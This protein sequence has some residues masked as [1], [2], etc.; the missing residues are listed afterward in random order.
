MCPCIKAC[1]KLRCVIFWQRAGDD[2]F[3]STIA[4]VPSTEAL[5]TEF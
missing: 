4:Y 5:D 2:R 3:D 1:C